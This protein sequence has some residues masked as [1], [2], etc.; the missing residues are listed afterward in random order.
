MVSE[1]HVSNQIRIKDKFDMNAIKLDLMV[2][3]ESPD[4]ESDND[5]DNDLE[6]S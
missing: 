4:D 6:D 3:T 5:N 2:L 1:N